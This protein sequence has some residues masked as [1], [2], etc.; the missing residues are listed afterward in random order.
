MKITAIRTI[1]LRRTLSRVQR[2]SLDTRQER[3][4]TFVIVETDA[5]FRRIGDA[6]GNQALME[7]IIQLRLANMAMGL[8][9]FDISTLWKKLFGSSPFWEVGGSV[10]C[11]IS[12][13]EV[14]C[15]DIQ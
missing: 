4:F 15:W 5:G 12:A 8:D 10:L 11:A 13:I 2:N 1:Q 3:R 6:F 14:A 7:P 9:P